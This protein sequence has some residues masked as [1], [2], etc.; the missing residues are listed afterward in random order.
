[1]LK[2]FGP[3]A[4]ALRHAVT[5]S[6]AIVAIL[7]VLARLD[8]DTAAKLLAAVKVAL[9]GMADTIGAIGTIAGIASAWWAG[10]TATPTQQI[11]A[12]NALPNATVVP[13][14]PTKALTDRSAPNS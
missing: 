12:V 10:R 6:G 5:A 9:G 8:P 7:A 2:Y 11:A 14:D 3:T 4:A 13:V 1:M